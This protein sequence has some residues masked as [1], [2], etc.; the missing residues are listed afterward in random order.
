MLTSYFPVLVDMII[1]PLC[2]YSWLIMPLHVV[3]GVHFL[4][5]QSTSRSGGKGALFTRSGLRTATV[6]GN[7]CHGEGW[8]HRLLQF[9]V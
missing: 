6:R 5:L 3:A 8:Y 7:D 4:I 2:S 9:Y 1:L